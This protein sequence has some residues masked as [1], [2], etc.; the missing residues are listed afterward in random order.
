MNRAIPLLLNNEI[1]TLDEAPGRT[2]LSWLRETREL[3]GTKE[4]CAEGECGACAVLLGEWTGDDMNYRAVPAC[5]L[6]MGELSGRHLLTVEGLNPATGLTPIQRALVDQGAPQCGFCFPGIV[7]SLTGFFLSSNDLSVSDA[8][9]ALDGNICRC[10]GYASILRAITSLTEEYAPLLDSSLPR[11]E[12][13]VAWGILPN[14]VFDAPGLLAGLEAP[15]STGPTLLGGG[16]DLIVQRG[17]ELP[18]ADVSFLSRRPEL[19]GIRLD[20]DALVMGGGTTLEELRT[21]STVADLVPAFTSMAT[22]F[23]STLVRHRATVAGNLVNASPIGDLSVLLLALGAELDLIGESSERQLPLAEFF[24]GYKDL[25]LADREIIRSVRV[26]RSISEW[27]VSFEKV[28]QRRALD[29]ASVNSAAA[30][31]MEN[32]RFTDARISMGGVAPVPLLLKDTVEYLIGSEVTPEVVLKAADI[33]DGEIAPIDDVRGS[34]TYKRLLA[35]RVLMA[36]VLK[37]APEL[38]RFEEL[39]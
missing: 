38:V 5:L 24:L 22:V 6:P 35:R 20:D 12:Q 32:G 18:M 21:S 8:I 34:A 19:R 37:L 1:V 27:S 25:A 2:V 28:S 30:F 7:L 16:T 4:G 15:L 39:A 13:L 31:V 33:M 23:A 17:T 9:T 36:H 10:T 14:S 26:P 11:S 29:I 3:T